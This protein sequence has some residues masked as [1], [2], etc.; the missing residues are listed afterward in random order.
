MMLERE[1]ANI[2]AHYKKG[3]LAHFAE[4]KIGN[5]LKRATP[6]YSAAVQF[7]FQLSINK[8]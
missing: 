1:L 4:R 7:A 2:N 5:Y 6:T 3:N 8:H